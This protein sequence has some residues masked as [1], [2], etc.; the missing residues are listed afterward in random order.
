MTLCFLVGVLQSSAWAQCYRVTSVGSESTTLNDQIRPGEG[1][2]GAWCGACDG[3]NGLLGLP[4]VVNVSDPSFQPYPTLLASSVAPFPSYGYNGGYDPEWVF[5]RCEPT[6][7]VYEMYSTN[8]DDY[9]GGWHQTGDDAGNSVGLESA[10]QTVW[11]NVLLRLT[12]V[13]TGEYFTEIWKER[14]LTDLDIDSRGYVLV[15][16]K[17]FSAVRSELFSAPTGYFPNPFYPTNPS[18]I[19]GYVGLN[20]YIAFKGP[21]IPYPEVGEDHYGNYAGWPPYWPGAI[22]MYM[23]VTVKRYPTCAVTNVT[24]VV[25][26]PAI[27]VSELNDGGRREVPFDVHFKCQAGVSSGVRT[28]DPTGNTAMGLLVSPGSLA[29]SQELGLVNNAGGVTYLVADRYGQPGGAQGVGIR[30]FRNGGP[31]NLLSN[32]NSAGGVQAESKGWYPV[33]GPASTLTGEEGGISQYV[34]TFSASL[35]KLSRG[36]QPPV[37]PGKV[38]A[39]AQVIIR[40]Q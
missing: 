6:D 19:Q 29:N 15:K 14:P 40:V 4:S 31:I 9:W 25:K 8:A 26:F 3:Q 18:Q 12:N 33:I 20:G 39:S 35:E 10:Y 17:N 23:D 38:E 24:P 27:T 5:Y 28:T 2:A 30:I 1:S 7:Q 37:T 34:E 22:G 13:T 21:G 32:E 16:A 11:P 36:T